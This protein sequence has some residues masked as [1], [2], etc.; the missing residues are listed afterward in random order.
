MPIAIKRAQSVVRQPWR[1]DSRSSLDTTSRGEHLTLLGAHTVALQHAFSEQGGGGAEYFAYKAALRSKALT[2]Q[3]R[4]QDAT[5]LSRE[6]KVHAC[7]YLLPDCSLLATCP[8][9]PLPLA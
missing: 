9:P 1:V 6:Q 2:S 5:V 7:G 3:G 4:E 8:P